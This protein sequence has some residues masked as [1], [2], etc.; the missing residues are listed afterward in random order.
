[1]ATAKK[2]SKAKETKKASK[3]TGAEVDDVLEGKSKKAPAKKAAADDLLDGK[4]GKGKKAPA[5]K[6]K[7]KEASEGSMTQ[8]VRDYVGKCRKLTSYADV[9]E[10]T[11]ADIRM[12]RRTARAMRDAGEIE[13]VKEG[14]VA[15]VKKS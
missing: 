5:K 8:S 10:A 13:I 15:F 1:M 2:A 11:G 12:V 3:A 4:S 9:A 7:A 6:A 14:T